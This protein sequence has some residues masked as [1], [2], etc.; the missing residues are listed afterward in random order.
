V[1]GVFDSD[2]RHRIAVSDDLPSAM[3]HRSTIPSGNIL[4]AQSASSTLM[5]RIIISL[6]LNAVL[7]LMNWS[8]LVK[9]SPKAL[10]LPCS[11]NAESYSPQLFRPCSR[12][13]GILA[14]LAAGMLS[15]VGFK[16]LELRDAIFSSS[17]QASI[18][19]P[20]F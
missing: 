10:S 20:G 3:N 7:L 2:F 14:R 6:A 15:R 16:F 19:Q 18:D 12:K 11:S 9:V 4:D 8:Y 17:P 5:S 1:Q 13:H